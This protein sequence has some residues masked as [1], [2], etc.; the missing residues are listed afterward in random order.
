MDI[1]TRDLSRLQ[2]SAFAAE[3]IEKAKPLRQAWKVQYDDVLTE[4]RAIAAAEVRM[5]EIPASVR[6]DHFPEIR[7]SFKGLDT[8]DAAKLASKADLETLSALIDAGQLL[9]GLSDPAWE[10]VQNRYLVLATVERLGLLA[11][12]QQ[13]PTVD[14]LLA[15]GPDFSAAEKAV[16]EML[17]AHEQR[18]DNLKNSVSDRKLS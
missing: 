13:I 4:K 2:P 15:T 5:A 11:N 6:H 9:T 1:A 16:R 14:N 3:I 17:A 18:K 12:Y 8:A 7:A 10:I